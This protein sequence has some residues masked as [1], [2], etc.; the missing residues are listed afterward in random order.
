M[1]WYCNYL[2]LMW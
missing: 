1:F 2:V